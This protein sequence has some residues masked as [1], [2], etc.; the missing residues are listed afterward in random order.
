ME[1]LQEYFKNISFRRIF[2]NKG[3]IAPIAEKAYRNLELKML[4][5]ENTNVYQVHYFAIG[6]S[7]KNINTEKLFKVGLDEE[8]KTKKPTTFKAL[9]KFDQNFCDDIKD[10]V[11]NSIRNIN[12]HYIHSFDKLNV[13]EINSEII[14]FLKDSFELAVIN[15][16]LKENKHLEIDYINNGLADAEL[17]K[18]LCNKFLPKNNNTPQNIKNEQLI[19]YKHI[20]EEFEKLTFKKALETILFVDVN[21]DFEWLVNNEIPAFNITKGKYLSYHACLFLLTIF[22]YKN[23]ANHLISKIKG[24]KKQLDQSDRSKREI[25]TFYSK[26]FSS[27]DI[28]SEESHLIKFRDIIQY[29][30]LYPTAWKN[31]ILLDTKYPVMTS[32]LQAKI[33]DL[34]I[35]RAYPIA[36]EK[37]GERFKNYI[38]IKF[39]NQLN[40]KQDFSSKEIEDFVYEIEKSPTYKDLIKKLLDLESKKISSTREQ[41]INDKNLVKTKKQIQINKNLVNPI[42]EKLRERISKN[43]VLI[44]YGRNQER[45]MQFAARFLAEINYFGKDAKFK[46]YLFYSSTEHFD[47]L[48]KAKS[49]LSKKKFDELKFHQGRI[50]DFT[51]FSDHHKLYAN[52]DTPFVVENNS[53]KVKLDFESGVEKIVSIQRNLMVYLL[54]DALYSKE[55]ERENSGIIL[56]ENYY[57][58]HTKEFQESINTLKQ[59]S[60]LTTEEKTVFAK[61]FPK[62]LLNNYLPPIQ[63]NTLERS[64]IELLLI[65]TNQSEERYKLLKEKAQLEGN[66]ENFINK[67]K[68]KQFKAQFIRKAWNLMYFRDS[69]K[70]QLAFSDQH[71]KN[72]HITREEFNDFSRYLFAFDEVPKYKIYLEELL[73]SK[74]FFENKEFFEIFQRGQSIDDFYIVT[75]QFYANWIELNNK[76]TFN[77]PKYNLDNYKD[78]FENEM[79]YIN[80]SH[81]TKYLEVENKLKRD[82]K[83]R[84]IFSALNNNDYLIQEYYYKSELDKNE[85]KNCGK[86]YNK[87]KSIRLED[88]LLYEIGLQYLKLE[89]DIINQSRANVKKILNQNL[90]FNIQEEDKHLYDLTLP[91]NKIEAFVELIAYKRIQEDNPKTK[92]SFMANIDKYLLLISS[93]QKKIGRKITKSNINSICENYIKN[94]RLT[95]S[96]IQEINNNILTSSIRFS[97]IIMDIEKY[98]LCKKEGR[99]STIKLSNK[100]KYDQTSGCFLISFKSTGV[101]QEYFKADKEHLRNKAFHFGIPTVTTYDSHLLKIEKKFIKEELFFLESGGFENLSNSQKSIC[102]LFLKLLHSDFFKRNLNGLEM[103]RHA[104]SKYFENIIKLQKVK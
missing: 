83:G 47:A 20:Q 14:L 28:N 8:S 74:G 77:K 30:N 98:F 36:V 67:N 91:F 70:K 13:D 56:M 7:F 29:L 31:E 88:A 93:E 61:I 103:H 5:K 96:E 62:R 19:E 33:I 94:K 41:I 39:W 26:K 101:Q 99:D 52:W 80:I 73:D 75:K 15:I 65:K 49:D 9:Q 57:K 4:P 97:K 38:K 35:E 64:Y 87:L 54:E 55:S 72:Y 10:K 24:F 102:R 16:F 44:S 68:G 17:V 21:N 32:K 45:F 60:Y 34:E 76:R 50:V 40:I 69:Y 71:H 22:L 90:T 42:T 86:L 85:Y 6:H 48:K 23:E 79:F 27:Q 3:N 53:I 63:N 25:F 1:K 43:L 51:K 78:I 18:Y 37:W 92:S 89:N 66:S 104:E 81:F 95:F 58:Y 11:I 59:R 46:L 100:G 82:D 84:M 2:E 12:S